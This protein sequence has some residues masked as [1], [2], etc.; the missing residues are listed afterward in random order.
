MHEILRAF[1]AGIPGNAV[2]LSFSLIV[3]VCSALSSARRDPMTKKCQNC[4]LVNYAE[5]DNC[6]RCDAEL[7]S[8]SKVVSS[9]PRRPSIGL[10]IAVC[11]GLTAVAL[12]IF[13]F[14]LVASSRSLSSEQRQAVDE[15]IG[16]IKTQ[17][18]DSE[19]MFLERFC[20][21]RSSDNWL[22][23]L[24]PKENAFAATNFPFLIMTLYSDFFT[25]PADDVERSAILLHEARHLRGGDEKDAYQFV[26][27][28]RVKLGWTK[29]KYANSPVWK[30][31]RRQTREYAPEIFGCP[32][33]EFEDCTEF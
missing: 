6:V 20:V 22:N 18:F 1:I 9:R 4:R 19:A 7:S 16:L 31:V 21:Y 26:W 13:Y 29:E 2:R 3:A 10:R 27:R 30:N 11:L 8:G 23:S 32:D 25:Y 14:S 12:T 28:N 5:A 33:K 24:T 15:A 17:G